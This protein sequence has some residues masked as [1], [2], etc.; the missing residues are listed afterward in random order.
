MNIPELFRFGYSIHLA[1][2]LWELDSSNNLSR[3][4]Q[5]GGSSSSCHVSAVSFPHCTSP[6]MIEIMENIS[7]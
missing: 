3:A 5:S 6:A 2:E 4:A 7:D 1:G